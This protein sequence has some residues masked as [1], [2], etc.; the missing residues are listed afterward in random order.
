MKIR[1]TLYTE[2]LLEDT[3]G[4]GSLLLS[5]SAD[6]H[7][8]D[9]VIA[10]KGT[11]S[12]V[13]VLAENTHSGSPVRDE[14]STTLHDERARERESER[15]RERER[16]RARAGAGTDVIYAAKGLPYCVHSSG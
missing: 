16:A 6:V 7:S 4:R 11:R 12:V 10:F 1:E 3:D 13:T 2:I 5:L 9:D 14:R 15:A 8:S